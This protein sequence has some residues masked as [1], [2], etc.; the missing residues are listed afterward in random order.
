MFCLRSG[1]LLEKTRKIIVIGLTAGYSFLAALPL[2]AQ[3]GDCGCTNCP[4]FMP[5]NFTG[6]FLITVQN[7]ANPTLGQNGQGVCGVTMNF[8]H[9]Y[10]GDLQ[11][12]LTSPAGQTVTLVGPIGLFGMTDFTTWDVTFVPCGDAASPDPGFSATW[13]NNQP[14]GMFG[15]YTGSYWPFNGCLENFNTGSVN[16]TWTLT[17]VDG[18]G[19]DVGNFYDYDIIFCDPS[20]IN[21]FTCA[22]NAGNLLQPD[23]VECEGS[24]N[25]NLDLPPTYPGGAMAPPS[26]EYSYTYV[27]GGAGGVIQGYE[28]GPDLSAYPAG[29]Y[30]V[31]GL[32]YLTAQEGDIP[33]P[34]GSLT[35]TQL[36]NQ[37]NS[38]SPPFCGKITTNCVT[39][40][41]NPLPD[42]IFEEATVCAGECYSFYGQNYCQS[43]TFIRNLTLN[44][45]PYTATLQL[46]VLP[47]IIKNV[48]E[49]ICEGACAQTPGFSSACSAG[50]YQE[51]FT[52]SNGC[53]SLVRLNLNVLTVNAVITPPP[54]L[55]CSPPTLILQS[56]GS[57]SGPGVTYSWTASNGGNIVAG[58]N[59]PSATV[60]A[61]GDYQLK[62]CRTGAGATCCDSTSVTVISSQLVPPAPD[63]IAGP[64]TICAGQ[65]LS[66]TAAAVTGA[67]GY[68][69]TAPAGVSIIAGQNTP[70]VTLA[71]DTLAG[72]NVCVT[73]NNSCGPSMPTCFPV[74]VN[75]PPPAV[76]PLGDT[77]LCINTQALYTVQAHPSAVAYT[78]TVTPPGSILSGQGAD[79]V[80]VGW[81][82]APAATLCVEASNACGVG[83]DTC[84]NI[85]FDSIPAANG[86][87]GLFSL[88]A[89]ASAWY[90]TSPAP[91]AT[92]YAWQVSGGSILGAAD[93][94]SVQIQWDAGTPAG[95][96][97][98]VVG[99]SCGLA[100]PVCQ[101]VG[102]TG[103]PPAPT[104]A[105]DTSLCA[106]ATG[107]YSVL[108]TPGA[109]GYTWTLPAGASLLAGQNTDTALVQWTQAPGGLL[110]VRADGVCGSS[111]PVCL[112]VAVLAVPDA[113]A[114]A[115]GATCDTVLTVQAIPSV[116]GS[117]GQW[118]QVSGPGA[119]A[120]SDPQATAT[121][122]SAVVRGVYTARW[123]ET[124]GQCADS[125]TI[126]LVFR[127]APTAGLPVFSCDGANQNYTV[128]YA[129][130]GGT[131]PYSVNGV[132]ISGST[133]TSAPIPNGQPYSLIASDTFGCAAAPLSGVYNCQCATF[134]GSMNQTLLE[135][136]EGAAVTA[137]HLGGQTLDAD[138]VAAYLLHTGAGAALGAVLA[139]NTAG[140]FV[141]QPGVMT[142]GV[143]YY[144]SLVA[145]SNLNGFP[146]P[147]DPCLSVS[148][149]QPVI[150]YQNP[151]PDAGADAQTCGLSLTLGASGSGQ[152]SVIGAPVGSS[153]TL[154]DPGN[155]TA[156]ANASQAGVYALT[157]TT[158]QNGCIGTDTVQLQFNTLP[159]WSNLER[160][161]DSTNQSYTVSFLI[162]GGAPPYTVNGNPVT[163]SLF[164]S[165]PLPNGQTFSFTVSDANNCTIAPITGSFSCNCTTDAG[166]MSTQTLTACVGSGVVAQPLNAP[167]L[168]ANDLAVFVLH[169]G[170]GPSLGTI[171]AQNTTGEFFFL[172]GMILGTTYYVSRVVGN[173]AGGTFDPTDPCLSVAPGQPVVFQA[174]PAPDAGPDDAVCGLTAGLLSDPDNVAG[175]WSQVSGPTAAAFAAPASSATDVVVGAPGVYV[176][177]WTSD[178][179][180]CSGSDEVEVVF[181]PEPALSGIEE[182]CNSANTAYT[183]QFN[184]TGGTAPFQVNGA[185]GSF[186]GNTFETQPIPNNTP[187]TIAVTDA[188]GCAAPAITGIQNCLCTT[189]AGSMSPAEQVFCADVPATGIW[190]NDAVL[191]GND[192]LRF[193]LHDQPGAVLGTVYAV[194]DQPVFAFGP[195]L[196]TGVTY[197]ISAL[198]GSNLNGQ[199]DPNDPCRSLAPGMPV[200]WRPLPSA[201]LSGDNTVCQGQ[202]AVLNFTASGDYP[203]VLSYTDGAA[204]QT[205]TIS[206][207]LSSTQT[208]TPAT[209]TVYTLLQAAYPSAP[210]CPAALNATAA[211]TVN[212]PVSSGAGPA[213]LRFCAG[214]GPVIW[215]DT[216]LS[217]ADA[218]GAW[219]YT[220]S[221]GLPAGAFN[222]ANAVLNAG[223]LAPGTY[224]F[225]YRVTAPA[226]CPSQETAVQFAVLPNPVADAGTDISLNCA[227]TSALLG[228]AATTL[229]IDIGYRWERD[230]VV[231]SD[232]RQFSVQDSGTY[233]L[234]VW[235]KN[236]GCSDADTVSVFSDQ[237]VPAA[238]IRVI[239]ERCFGENNGVIEVDSVVSA[240]P[241]V[242][243]A[244]Q[245][246]GNAGVF[247][248]QTR[249]EGLEPGIYTIVLQDALG[250][251]WI[252]AEQLVEQG[253]QLTVDLGPPDMTVRLGDEATI[254]LQLSVSPALL[255]TIRWM[256][257]LDSSAVNQPYQRFKP[258]HSQRIQVQVIDANGCEAEDWILVLLDRGR[259]VYIPT[260]FSPSSSEN[261]LFT[262]YGGSDV[263]EIELLE[264]FDRWGNKMFEARNFPPNS[265]T[266]GWNGRYREQFVQPGVYVYHTALRFADGVRETYSGDITVYR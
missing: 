74:A 75:T 196:Q 71:W 193:V 68:T 158:V 4:Q 170:A 211:V 243:I 179:G 60:N 197:Y 238:A 188:N 10:L 80:L 215:L 128:T 213:L 252:S 168:D 9:E 117:T 182:I 183:V 82:S 15:A 258:T 173:N 110:C 130:S 259:R 257:L 162:N 212:E 236:T 266:I 73:A 41:I 217:G 205:L 149:G 166:D 48:N 263:V 106:G 250:C 56:T 116:G 45:C 119:L 8:D 26:P 225:A 175:A 237:A 172:P 113:D 202:S 16:G 87:T 159:A 194:S 161:C 91:G 23:V 112:P 216:L 264:V 153:L 39:V 31:C 79:S 85:V 120:F 155:P 144:I 38:S 245:Q 139:Q 203:I 19:N 233:R 51:I 240:N 219:V 20:G 105:G 124:N 118:T 62:I 1:V 121:T 107:S 254:E 27:I 223:L 255:D 192:V 78:W 63:S 83:P 160:L 29:I 207:P 261:N 67:T 148:V 77:A 239:P 186:A 32:S 50:Q 40:T 171:L 136:C 69:W 177:R 262:V 260:I 95:S 12:T 256:P 126:T 185:A 231:V 7:A 98:L 33:A 53:D 142:Y 141:F 230:G 221:A 227:N 103:A 191:D 265:T 123:T 28:P 86:L 66:L 115:D 184:I 232:S 2:A 100:A 13:N 37:L 108:P 109:T 180:V 57:S 61:P 134:A 44:G 234:T 181:H 96:V 228:G 76:L 190:N 169:T 145:G 206:G 104:L 97:C 90:N 42:D 150:F 143:T 214:A 70:G 59:N 36:S 251:Q 229:G 122:A 199:V 114:G 218:S 138:D 30:T 165:S 157:W 14:W 226:P 47:P 253:Q 89:G 154:S 52:A 210:A 24:M 224:T 152:W 164:T 35:V 84:L 101:S 249:F 99:N 242:L 198:A 151:S 111:A 222:P 235:N 93:S 156:N 94:T 247:G 131:P 195:G 21:C 65:T 22:A 146:D 241:P 129:F 102:F 5:D 81:G 125:D 25:L 220:S 72:G 132:P 178:N 17:V 140:V 248:Y 133:Y 18:Q 34:N 204:Q 189:D 92:S 46:T 127:A 201:I 6:S 49:T 174:L 64:G 176:F 167:V 135:A 209:T 3:N 200:R 43:G 244:L 54:P 163:G 88:C 137:Q 147:A 58:T 246:P 11:I 208:V 55:G 187:Y